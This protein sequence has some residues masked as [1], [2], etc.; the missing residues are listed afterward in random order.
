MKRLRA[1][2]LKSKIFFSI[3]AVILFI[4][5][6]IAFLARWILVSS[7]TSELQH[8][9]L[10]IAQSIADRAS[11]YILDKNTPQMVSLVF[12][13][14]HLGERR[15]L[16]AYIFITDTDSEIL[17]H[18]FTRPFP[19]DLKRANILD[20][21]V[22]QA[23]E[24]VEVFG[25]QALDIAVPVKEG[26]YQ[27]GTVHV[28]LNKEHI[29]NLV[30]KLR[31]TFLGFIL[32]IIIIVFAVSLRLT[33]SITR[34][35]QKL[36]SISDELSRG[37]FDIKLDFA[38]SGWNVLDCPAY[39]NTDLPCWHF[40][41]TA[42]APDDGERL[43]TCAKCNFY[44]KRPGDEVSQLADSF[45]NMVW[46]IKLYRRRL[47]ESEEKYRSLFV[48]GP[49]PVFVVDHE[50]VS[51]LDANPR[52]EELYGY[53]RGELQGMNFM[54]LDP[55]FNSQCRPYF[56]TLGEEKSCV[57]LT[58][59][60]HFKRGRQPFYVNLHAC[61]ISYKGRHAVII[62]VTDITEMIEKDAQLIQAS[63]MKTLGE[64]SAGIAHE[65]NQPLNAIKM[66]SDFLSMMSE[67]GRE[68]PTENM[69]QVTVEIS[70]QVD[71]ATEIINTLRAF[72]RKAHFV[73]ELLD[74]NRS[75]RGVMNIVGQQFKLSN[76]DVELDLAENLPT[77]LAHD[78]RLQQVLFN[79]VSNAR[80]AILDRG[81]RVPGDGKIVIRTSADNG[82][83]T[84]SVS[85]TGVGIAED[86]LH[87][88]FE[89]FFTTKELGQGMGLGLSISY[90]IVKDYNGDIRIRSRKGEGSTFTLTFPAA[91]PQA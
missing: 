53:S 64:M 49:D 34:P 23:F 74:V 75:I 9:G 21:E 87:K 50:D 25:Q 82:S 17:A 55:D 15:Q 4:S 7:L 31:I 20:Q 12:D 63:K 66:G 85:D 51:I 10:A 57:Y 83:V 61:P 19:P 27:I 48:S 90:G 14:A 73:K 56:D 67:Q 86:D 36:I 18:T 70:A 88:V 91:K 42:Q 46:S 30:G 11:G 33:S 79:L 37:N 84:V 69:H 47:R 76:V 71:R 80:D 54:D 60:M 16:I 78:N 6:A 3:L 89:P 52:A 81:D 2:G 29:D 59:I 72:G 26:I 24:S 58:K 28:G 68:I 1:L 40:D 43:H 38:D 39:R 41:Q 44:R 35:I 62:A 77:I 32:L 45:R 5:V 22:P 13:T 8:R 65:L